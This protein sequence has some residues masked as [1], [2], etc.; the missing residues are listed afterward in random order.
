MALLDMVAA[1]RRRFADLIDSLTPEQLDTPSLCGAWTVKEVA[2]HV[3]APFAASP[4]WFLPLILRSRLSLHRANAELARMVAR[5]PAAELAA[6]LRRNERNAF[7]PPVVGLYGQLTDLQVHGQ[8]VRRPL[9][10]PHRLDLAHARVSLD[11]LVSRR[12]VAF[13]P[14]RL[15]AGLRFAATDLDWARGDGPEVR[16]S[17]EA[18]M[19]ALTGRLVVLPELT[20][21]GADTFRA[22]ATR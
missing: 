16:G 5:R 14:R 8:D 15:R 7:S 9:G 22:R 1:E 20:G 18:L 12:S 13:G 6:E 19:M 2:G 11:F 21:D 17:A 3:V 10:L 4:R